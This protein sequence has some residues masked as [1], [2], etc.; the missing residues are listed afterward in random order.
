MSLKKFE[1]DSNPKILQKIDD[2]DRLLVG[3]EE[4]AA[5]A[6]QPPRRVHHWLKTGLLKTPRKVGHLWTV[7]RRQFRRELGLD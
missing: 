4:M 6:G 1:C 5:E 7:G 2:G 3:A